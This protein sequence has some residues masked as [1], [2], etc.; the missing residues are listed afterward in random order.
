LHILTGLR[1]LQKIFKQ[2]IKAMPLVFDIDFKN[3][4]FYLE[5]L[6]IGVEIGEGKGIEKG[7]ELG[8]DKKA[9]IIAENMLL[10]GKLPI[11]RIAEFVE[12]TEEFI[13]SIQE[14]LVSEGKLSMKKNKKK[15]KIT[16]GV[17]SK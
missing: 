9:I 4:P 1:N 16:E 6:E 8:V 7:I 17:K 15:R 2:K 3:D 5:G 14:R 11:K 10:D 13:L 12:K